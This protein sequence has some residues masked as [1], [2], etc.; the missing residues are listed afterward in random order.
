[1]NL[2]QVKW[3]KHVKIAWCT[4]LAHKPLAY[5]KSL[6]WCP[7][8]RTDLMLDRNL[9][10]AHLKC[11]YSHIY[12]AFPSKPSFCL[13]SFGREAHM[14]MHSPATLSF[15]VERLSDK[16]KYCLRPEIVAFLDQNTTTSFGF[17][18]FPKRVKMLHQLTRSSY[19]HKI[20]SISW[21]H[22]SYH[23]SSDLLKQNIKDSK[24]CCPTL[25]HLIH[26]CI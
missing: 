21:S 4:F 13:T 3:E 5:V 17:S 12:S 2:F 23:G 6:I 19:A 18:P 14:Q 16:M 20:R 25:T 15:Q 8:D 26:S 24:N 22:K 10:I 11:T 7:S 9:I 1:M